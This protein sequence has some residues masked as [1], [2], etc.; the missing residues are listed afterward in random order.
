MNLK[1][2]FCQ[3]MHASYVHQRSFPMYKHFAITEP[4]NENIRTR[5]MMYGDYLFPTWFKFKIRALAGHFGL[6]DGV[7]MDIGSGE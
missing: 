5:S 1:Y 3:M 4:G 2:D 7:F 6:R